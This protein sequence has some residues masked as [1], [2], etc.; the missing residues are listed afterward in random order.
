MKRIVATQRLNENNRNVGGLYLNL[1]H[2]SSVYLGENRQCQILMQDGTIYTTAHSVSEILDMIRE[3]NAR[4][5]EHEIKTY[6]DAYDLN[7]SH[8]I[9]DL[10]RTLK[11]SYQS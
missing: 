10:L 6:C 11:S 5:L 9:S 1:D 4:T 2:I 3:Q 8:H 7:H